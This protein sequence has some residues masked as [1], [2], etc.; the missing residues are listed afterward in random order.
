MPT[1]P[2]RV[3]ELYGA[4]PL[5]LLAMLASL[6][7]AGYVVSVL[8]PSALWDP[9]VWWQSIAVWFLGAVVAHDLVLFPLYALADRSYA[10]TVRLLRR[11]L[12]RRRR[13]RRTAGP[14]VS[15]LNYVRVPVLASALLL[16]LFFPGIVEQGANSYVAATGQT[17]EPFLRR[18]LLLTGSFFAAAAVAYALRLRRPPADP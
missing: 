13:S 11:L 12:R 17:Q 2:A 10:G 16:L 1:A 5:H 6:A 8:G 9:D 15:A 18:W 14:R 7:L 4:G 3:R